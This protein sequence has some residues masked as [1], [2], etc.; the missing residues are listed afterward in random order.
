MKTR[1]DTL[2]ITD[3]GFFDS[4]TKFP[5]RGTTEVR[6]VRNFEVEFVANESKGKTI[7][8]GVEYPLNAGRVIVAKPGTKRYTHLVGL[9]FQ[10]Y[11][12]HLKTEDTALQE[13]LFALPAS[14]FVKDVD[15]YVNAMQNILKISRE[16]MSDKLRIASSVTDILARLLEE[17][18]IPDLPAYQT[19]STH[20][21]VLLETRQYMDRHYAEE[22]DL[23]TL[24][25]IA[26]LSPSYFHRLFSEAFG[27]SPGKYLQNLRLSAAKVMLITT[28]CPIS[29]V[30]A[31]T[32]FS[33]QHYF[34]GRF[35]NA[36]AISPLKFRQM[37]Q[38]QKEI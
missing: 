27:I 29:E 1:I 16:K 36:F 32:G 11:Y 38:R 37:M 7:I 23:H 2:Y 18:T 22:I 6:D 17:D 30:A 5:L 13:A 24:C 20:K 19:F 12:L 4:V 3:F 34:T 15:S 26:N 14:F 31:S 35:K 9:A 10:C 28:N 21:D 8:D 25:R 33:S